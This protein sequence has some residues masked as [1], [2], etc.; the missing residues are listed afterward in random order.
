MNLIIKKKKNTQIIMISSTLS[1]GGEINSKCVEKIERK[2]IKRKRVVES[3]KESENITKW[4]NFFS[5]CVPKR[6]R[7]LV[8]T[9]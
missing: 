9:T 5:F 3:G 1:F 7:A 4:C 8:A 6:K 2:A